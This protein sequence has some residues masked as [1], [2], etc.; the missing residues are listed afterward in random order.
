MKQAND[1]YFPIRH[2]D[3]VQR[4]EDCLLLYDDGRGEVPHPADNLLNAVSKNLFGII[5]VQVYRSHFES[6]ID[7]WEYQQ[8]FET[9]VMDNV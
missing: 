8:D 7:E 6:S 1:A 2:A 3:G 4:L 5:R 9:S